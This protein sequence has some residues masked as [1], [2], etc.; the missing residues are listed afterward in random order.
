MQSLTSS[1]TT[2]TTTSS[3]LHHARA[4]VVCMLPLR[5]CIRDGKRLREW[6]PALWHPRLP[7]CERG[8]RS[9]RSAAQ[10]NG[11]KAGQGRLKRVTSHDPRPEG[12]YRDLFPSS[13]LASS[14]INIPQPPRRS[15]TDGVVAAFRNAVLQMNLVRDGLPVVRP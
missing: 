10:K 12:L 14:C 3:L 9:T 15:A 4:V 8:Q 2:I 6:R 13:E 1:L 7:V 5:Q 11:G